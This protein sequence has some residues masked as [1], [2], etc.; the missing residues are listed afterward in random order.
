MVVVSSAA[1]FAF[2]L[3][4]SVIAFRNLQLVRTGQQAAVQSAESLINLQA[5]FSMLQDAET[6]QRGFLITGDEAYLAPYERALGELATSRAHLRAYA[7]AQ[8]DLG[9]HLDALEQASDR[10]VED[11]KTTLDVYRAQGADAAGAVVRQNEGK[12]HMDAV[13]GSVSKIQQIELQRREGLIEEFDSSVEYAFRAMLVSTA[14]GAGVI[15]ISFYFAQRQIAARH[16]LAKHLEDASNNK[17]EFLAMLGHELRNPLAAVR[18]AVDVLDL[19]GTLPET[20]EEMRQIIERQSNVMGRLV[21]GLLDVARISHGKIDLRKTRLNLVEVIERT[22][23]DVRSDVVRTGVQIEIEASENEIWID[24]DAT[25]ISQVVGNLLQNAIKFSDRSDVVLVQLRITGERQ[26]MLSVIDKGVGMAGETLDKIFELY[27]QGE[28][29]RERR[30]GL[31]LGLA[32]ARGL[33]ELHGGT[34]EAHSAG[35]GKG[36]TFIVMLPLAAQGAIHGKQES[37]EMDRRHAKCR[38]VVIDDR[39]DSSFTLRRMLELSG[40][41]VYVAEEGPSG[42]ALARQVKPD[43]VL[44]DLD[45]PGGM[46]GYDIVQELRAHEETRHALI[47]AVTGH[48]EAEARERSFQAGFDRHMVKPLSRAQLHEILKAVPCD[49]VTQPQGSPAAQSPRPV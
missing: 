31:G 40:H 27:A 7:E 17:N 10:K 35:V 2:L 45:L 41:E 34:I 23:T 47:V 4:S 25:R 14:I 38:V 19:V 15:V 36:S 9:K 44:C 33:V 46:S 22:V 1:L 21:D 12:R 8:P 49:G 16:Q 37:E 42:V 26:A 5:M 13:R 18:N 11:L 3:L 30:A 24:G 48:A 6:G 32:L 29:A 28:G 43:I 39:R 20:A